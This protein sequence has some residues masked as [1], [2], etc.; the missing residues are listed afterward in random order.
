MYTR[1][2]NVLLTAA[3]MQKHF[4]TGRFWLAR[5]E[6]GG[7]RSPGVDQRLKDRGLFVLGV[8]RPHHPD[9][10][11]C[12]LFPATHEPYERIVGGAE[13]RRLF[14][15]PG[16]EDPV[17][18]A[19]KSVNAFRDNLAPCVDG[20]EYGITVST[21]RGLGGFDS[22]SGRIGDPGIDRIWDAFQPTLAHFIALYD[23]GEMRKYFAGLGLPHQ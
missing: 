1:E 4:A 18:E 20:W 16:W 17:S 12:L 11:G 23:D 3:D 5:I 6:Y 8:A 21:P 15:L 14:D 19:L 10:Q 7:L 2:M 13:P 22:H 9:L